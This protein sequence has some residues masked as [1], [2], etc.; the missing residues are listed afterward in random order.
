MFRVDQQ[1]AHR[2]FS[3]R[4]RGGRPVRGEEQYIKEWRGLE[5]SRKLE[6]RRQFFHPPCICVYVLV[7]CGVFSF[8][9]NDV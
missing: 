4:L 7:L 1:M 2:G 9:Q 8:F 6:R 3:I 5:V